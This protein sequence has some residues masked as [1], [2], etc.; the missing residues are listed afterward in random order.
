M[1]RPVYLHGPPVAWQIW[2]TNSLINRS[3]SVLAYFWLMRSS[4]SWRS[5][6]TRTTPVMA[7]VPPKRSYRERTTVPPPLCCSH[8]RTRTGSLAPGPKLDATPKLLQSA[9][10]PLPD[11][12]TP[13]QVPPQSGACVS[14]SSRRPE[15]ASPRQLVLQPDFA[16]DRELY[17]PRSR[18]IGNARCAAAGVL[19]RITFTRL[20][21]SAWRPPPASRPDLPLPAASQT[22]MTSAGAQASSGLA[23]PQGPQCAIWVEPGGPRRTGHAR[24][25]WPSSWRTAPYFAAFVSDRG[26]EFFD[27]FTERY[28]AL[29][30]EQEVGTCTFY[31]LVAGDGSVLGQINLVLSEDG[32]A[33][34]GYRVAQHIASRGVATATVQELCRKAAQH[35]LHTLKAATARENV[36]SQKI[37][38][39]AGSIPVGPAGSA[40]LGGK[41]GTR[42]H[43][44]PTTGSP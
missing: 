9:T 17:L 29:L 12:L 5:T 39:I 33:E 22:T 40:H 11:V 42:Y 23:E 31:V 13:T 8:Q 37:L 25:S 14:A 32:T 38:T 27:Q 18:A 1:L 2:S 35:G 30:A 7:S 44:D 28:R 4:F 10:I 6:T 41:P 20:R 16:L 24:R 43:R 26:D 15:R 3:T 36:A 19:E 34:P 21:W